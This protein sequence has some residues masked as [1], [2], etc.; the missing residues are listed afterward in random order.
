MRSRTFLPPSRYMHRL[1]LQAIKGNR[2]SPE[3]TMIFRLID[4]A[5]ARIPS[6]HFMCYL[7]R[8]FHVLPTPR[9]KLLDTFRQT[10]LDDDPLSLSCP[11]IAYCYPA[12][13][14]VQYATHGVSPKH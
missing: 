11:P 6:A 9:T 13:L 7:H 14:E 12:I 5:P 8:T 4:P 2:T 1:G 3:Q 10:V